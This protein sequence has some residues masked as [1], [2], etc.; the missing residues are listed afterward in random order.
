MHSPSRYNLLHA[1]NSL[2]YRDCCETLLSSLNN[3]ARQFLISVFLLLLY[4]CKR[5]I[6][7]SGTVLMLKEES[8]C[9]VVI[10]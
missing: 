3:L 1:G 8:I 7:L 10:S 5:Q 4:H 9:P 2:L 6:R